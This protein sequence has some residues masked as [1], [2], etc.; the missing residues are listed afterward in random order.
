M[1]RDNRRISN[2]DQVSV[3]ALAMERGKGVGFTGLIGGGTSRPS[4][5]AA[6]V[7]GAVL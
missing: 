5:D 3:A 6:L 7:I 2:G 4:T 1:A